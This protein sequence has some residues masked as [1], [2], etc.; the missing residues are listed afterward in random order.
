MMPE[1]GQHNP[2]DSMAAYLYGGP[3]GGHWST[4]QDLLKLGTWI[5]GKSKE[6]TF[7]ELLKNHGRE[8]YNDGN[9]WHAGSISSASAH[10]THLGDQ[11]LTVAVLSTTKGFCQATAVAEMIQDHLII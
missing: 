9:V 6:T 5:G 4:A 3:G 10:L 2:E 7:G 11:G 8:F 1:N